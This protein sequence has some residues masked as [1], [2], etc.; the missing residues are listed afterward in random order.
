MGNRI[1]PICIYGPNVDRLSFFQ[2]VFNKAENLNN[3]MIVL[4]DFN[5]VIY[6]VKP[7]YK[8][9]HVNN[10]KARKEFLNQMHILNSTDANRDFHPDQ[11]Q[12]TKV[13]H[14]KQARLDFILISQSLVQ[15]V[16][17]CNI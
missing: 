4:G 8:Y 12:F 9:L 15:K 16:Q 7:Y 11:K 2:K 5:L 13:H 17:N 6:P 14:L 3:E 1:I 10:S